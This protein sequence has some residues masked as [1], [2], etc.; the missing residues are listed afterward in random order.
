M[1]RSIRYFALAAAFVA[2]SAL[3][4]Q[5]K[6][7]DQVKLRK[8]AYSL[9]N[10]NFASLEN[11]VKEKKP[12]NKDEAVRNA[13]FV[14]MLA[15]VPKAFFGEGTDKGETRAKP[16]IWTHRADFD[17]KM[18]KMNAEAAKLPQAARTGDLAALRKQ[19]EAT[20][21]ACRACHD[22]YRQKR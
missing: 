8:A 2:F 14:A 7:E 5:P 20:D 15:T 17:A 13:D 16:E 1:Q 22:D 6:P 21:H 4:Q 11:M 10:Y 9:M 19:V 3:A 18:D 12:Y